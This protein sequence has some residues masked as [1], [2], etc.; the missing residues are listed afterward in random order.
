MLPAV[1]DALIRNRL[2]LVANK[3]PDAAE[4]G[5]TY[6]ESRVAIGGWPF[7]VGI[8]G[9]DGR[10]EG[11]GGPKTRAETLFLV[12]GYEGRNIVELA[13]DPASWSGR[14]EFLR[15][16]TATQDPTANARDHLKAFIARAKTEAGIT[17]L[18]CC[19]S[20]SGA[21]EYSQ[22]R[23]LVWCSHHQL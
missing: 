21:V 4:Q 17:N 19:Q 6:L 8:P 18:P 23:E 2:F 7:D 5:R 15:P 3:M 10:N 13:D 16:G 12:K 9:A 20:L 1:A 22:R 14:A 11:S